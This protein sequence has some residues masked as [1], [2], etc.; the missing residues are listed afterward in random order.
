MNDSELELYGIVGKM[1]REIREEKGLSLTVVSEYL[2]IAPISL[3][4]YECGER[5]IKMGT[6]KKLCNFYRIEYDD[7]IK[8]AKL[9]FGKSV[10]DSSSSLKILKYYDQLNT[11]GQEAATEQVRLLTL[12]DKYTRPNQVIS[13]VREPEPDY[14]MPNA[15][16]L[17]EGADTADQEYDDKEIMDNDALWKK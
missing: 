12:D 9:R 15:A 13:V 2:Q 16:H 6:I 1:F 11:L 8:E 4:R 10:Y 5:K 14:L 3:Q 7:F 17:R